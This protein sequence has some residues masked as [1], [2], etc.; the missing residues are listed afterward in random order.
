LVA[1]S[2]ARVSATDA[3]T[4]IAEF[5]NASPVNTTDSTTT[6]VITATDTTTTFET[7]VGATIFGSRGN[8]KGFKTSGVEDDSGRGIGVF[9]EHIFVC[10]EI[11]YFRFGKVASAIASALRR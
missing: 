10:W 3:S 1:T 9:R 5:G 11:D 7:R 4:T 6:K 2:K 8:T